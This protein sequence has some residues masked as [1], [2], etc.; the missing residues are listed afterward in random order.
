MFYSV[1]DVPPVIELRG[2]KRVVLTRG[3]NLTL[4]CSTTNVNGDIKLKWA[5]PPGTVRTLFPLSEGLAREA[6]GIPIGQLSNRLIGK[7]IF[8]ELEQKLNVFFIFARESKMLQ[9]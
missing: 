6:G 9:V 4:T 2:P 1:P 5:A 8:I 3:Q 7:Y